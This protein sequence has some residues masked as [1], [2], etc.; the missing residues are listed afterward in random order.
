MT[1]L[2][3]VSSSG[4]AEA[5]K[6]VEIA[7]AQILMQRFEPSNIKS[8]QDGLFVSVTLNSTVKQQYI[9]G[10]LDLTF[11]LLFDCYYLVTIIIIID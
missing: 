8:A 6:G 1:T 10:P 7:A 5:S 3:L 11:L 2:P 4:P 9:H